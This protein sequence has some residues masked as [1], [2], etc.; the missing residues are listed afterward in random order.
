MRGPV[1]KLD[2][3][4]RYINDAFNVAINAQESRWSWLDGGIITQLNA[5]NKLVEYV[6][7][8]KFTSE[9]FLVIAG[10]AERSPQTI[11]ILDGDMHSF[12]SLLIGLLDRGRII[13]I[14]RSPVHPPDIYSRADVAIVG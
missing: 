1:I 9:T 4:P 11:Y 3:V 8:S 6:D 5:A 13:M 7:L 12:A 2:E 14:N 10:E